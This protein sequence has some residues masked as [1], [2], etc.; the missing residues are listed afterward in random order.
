MAKSS[1]ASPTRGAVISAW[2]HPSRSFQAVRAE[3]PEVAFQIL[4]HVCSSKIVGICLS[5]TTILGTGSDSS[6]EMQVDVADVR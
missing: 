3:M 4:A 2:R 1:R 5:S 6:G